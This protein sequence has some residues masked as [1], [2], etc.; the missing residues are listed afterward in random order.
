MS[1]VSKRYEPVT[2]GEDE[3][4]MWVNPPMSFLIRLSKESGAVEAQLGLLAEICTGSTLVGE[5][6]QPLSLEDF[7]VDI[8]RDVF[9][10]YLAHLRNVPKG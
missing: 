6:D 8:V 3:F 10:A 2:V 1:K 9:S 7:P 4:T 5:D